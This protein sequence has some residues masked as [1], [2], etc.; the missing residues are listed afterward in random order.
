MILPWVRPRAAYFFIADTKGSSDTLAGAAPFGEDLTV[1]VVG[2]GE[3]QPVPYPL[4]SIRRK[5]AF[6]ALPMAFSVRQWS[7]SAVVT[8]R[9][10]GEFHSPRIGQAAEPATA[11]SLVR[12]FG[13]GLISFLPDQGF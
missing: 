8:L 6:P 10:S 11:A 12:S 13:F 3:R 7:A 9:P 5:A 2:G 1:V 4:E